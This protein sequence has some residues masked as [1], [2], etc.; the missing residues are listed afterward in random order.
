MEIFYK[1]IQGDFICY[2]SVFHAFQFR[3]SLNFVCVCMNI[4]MCVEGVDVFFS[5]ASYISLN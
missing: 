3:H 2:L 5:T 4:C 1:G